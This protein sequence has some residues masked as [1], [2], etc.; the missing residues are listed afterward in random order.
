MCTFGHPKLCG[1][2]AGTFE[3]SCFLHRAG[4]V[5]NRFMADVAAKNEIEWLER[6]RWVSFGGHDR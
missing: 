6:L 3:F 5:A 4:D 1:W 2:F